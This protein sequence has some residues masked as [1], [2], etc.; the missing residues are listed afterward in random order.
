[1]N[2]RIV[3]PIAWLSAGSL[4][5]G[6]VAV[7]ATTGGRFVDADGAVHGCVA[8][9]SGT[10]RLVKPAATCRKAETSLVLGLRG[11]TGPAG[12]AGTSGATGAAGVTGPMG[13]AGATGPAGAA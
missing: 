3:S 6:G 5:A 11:M 2:L 7:A 4:L 9:K 10:L 1:M 13:P 8:R 12:S